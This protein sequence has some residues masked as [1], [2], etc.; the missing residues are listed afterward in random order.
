MYLLMRHWKRPVQSLPEHVEHV[1]VSMLLSDVSFISYVE[2]GYEIRTS[3]LLFHRG[4][5]DPHTATITDPPA[6]TAHRILL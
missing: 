3:N 1:E 2:M 6:V 5:G 4:K